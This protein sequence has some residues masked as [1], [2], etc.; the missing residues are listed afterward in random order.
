MRRPRLVRHNC[1]S[2]S[3]L[4]AHSPDQPCRRSCPTC[5]SVAEADRE[6]AADGDP[7]KDKE[8]VRIGKPRLLLAILTPVNVFTGVLSC[9]LICT[10][11]IWMDCRWLPPEL[12]PPK[13]LTALNVVSVLSFVGLGLKGYIDDPSGLVAVGSMVGILIAVIPITKLAER[14]IQERLQ[15]AKAKP[16]EGFMRLL[17]FAGGLRWTVT[18]LAMGILSPAFAEDSRLKLQDIFEIEFASDP[19][20]SPDG[21]TI[22]YVRNYFDIMTDRQN[23]N[24]WS[25]D[26]DGG[27]HRP[28]TTG[29]SQDAS[30]RWSP[31]GSRLLFLTKEKTD[32]AV[33]RT[34]LH[35]RWMAT[36]E[37]ACLAA[38]ENAPAGLTWSPDG[39]YIAFTMLA[40][41]KRKPFVSLPGRPKGAQWA[42]PPNV[43]RRIRYRYD[44]KGY[45]KDGYQHVFVIR[46]EGGTS[47]QITQGDFDHKGPLV[48]TPDNSIVCS[49]SRAENWEL[50]PRQADLYRVP[51]PGVSRISGS[52]NIQRVTDRRGPDHS[53]VFSPDGK[54]VA[55]LGFDDR[56]LSYQ[57]THLYLASTHDFL[58]GNRE[59]FQAVT[60]EFSRSVQN[61]HWTPGS[62]GLY[63]NYDDRGHGQLVHTDLEGH[64]REVAEDVGGTVIGRPY[65]G[66]SYSASKN[67]VLAFTWTS[68]HRPAEVAVVTPFGKSR[69]LTQLN[70]DLFDQRQLGKAEEFVFK[71]PNYDGRSIQAWLVTPPDFDAKKQYPLILEIHGGPFANYGWRFSAEMQMY[72]AAGYV[73][74][75]VNPRGSTSYGE[76][77][78]NQIH[79]SYPGVDYDDL[80]TA[81]DVVL[82][83][84]F[85]DPDR[86]FV[87]GGSGGGILTA[88]IVGKTDR[89]RAAVSAKPVINWYSFAL[90][91][92]I[93]PYFWQYWFDGYPWERAAEYHKRSPISLVGN[94]ETPTMLLTGEVDRRTPISETEQFYQALKLRGIDTAMVRIP[95]ASHGIVKRPSNLM[96][97]VA[98]ILKWF[99]IHDE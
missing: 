30:P 77:F 58:A 63:F 43:I 69:V 6:A 90:T 27:N 99:E 75:Y 79:K 18:I 82:K 40:E 54:Q 25:I 78:A 46:A 94:V 28:L 91:T 14:S 8:P 48:W 70:A 85:V 76:E 26:A 88:W 74:L 60:K 95:G 66:G 96:N 71:A 67:G 11:V 33:K 51:V 64:V 68:P 1:G 49:T 84:G 36:G 3:D 13:L 38:Y 32:R 16:V 50:D 72:A 89:F 62:D 12:Q 65:Q 37:S 10:L 53:A 81:V 17:H 93:Y 2:D 55:W 15:R 92:D 73:V 42:A 56:K 59:K 9:G 23:A 80:M 24:L 39:N 61:P 35:C 97:K 45:L 86:L 31:D 87:T 4:A 7:D 29:L 22:V 41:A 19:Q 34:E 98:H 44:G 52:M 20:I 83:R 57:E 21:K 47:R 5:H